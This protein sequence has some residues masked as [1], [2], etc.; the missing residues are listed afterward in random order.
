MRTILCIFLLAAVARAEPWCSPGALAASK[1]GRTIYIACET[2]RR[3]EVFDTAR[4][5]VIRRIEMPAPPTGL[6]VSPDGAQ[7]YVT[8]AAPKSSVQIID[9]A[10]WRILAS[11]PAGHTALAPVL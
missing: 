10:S 2:G 5:E 11:I 8:C 6:A 1:D 3:V 4:R 7:L 9:T